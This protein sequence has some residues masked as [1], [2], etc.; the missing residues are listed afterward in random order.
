MRILLIEDDPR[1]TES[2][3]YQLGKEGFAVDACSDAFD[4][5]HYMTAGGYDLVLLDRMLPGADGISLLRDARLQGAATPVIFLTAMGQL[6]DRIQGLDA[7]ADDYIVKP[8]AFGE[9]MARIRSVCR[10]PR[11][12][13]RDDGVSYGALPPWWRTA[14]W[15]TTYISC[16]EDLGHW[17]QSW[18]YP[19]CAAW[20]IC[21]RRTGG[22]GNEAGLFQNAV[23]I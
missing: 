7:G 13:G 18:G 22:M 19:Q 3:K 17:A 1:L 4:G 20:D 11:A 6:D 15:T 23:G 12:L 10:R 8:F 5:L 21:W 2:L 9:L 16:A 14:T